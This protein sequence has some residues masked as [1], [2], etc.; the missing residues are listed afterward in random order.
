MDWK[1]SPIDGWYSFRLTMNENGSWPISSA[2]IAIAF[3]EE[4]SSMKNGA[5][6]EIVLILSPT[7]IEHIRR[8]RARKLAARNEP[9]QVLWEPWRI[10][11]SEFRYREIG[12]VDL[13]CIDE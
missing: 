13:G 10:T 8:N 7:M 12:E 2:N 5:R 4:H 6:H 3:R 9:V 1:G 11:Q